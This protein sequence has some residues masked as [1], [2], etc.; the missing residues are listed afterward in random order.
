MISPETPPPHDRDAEAEILRAVIFDNAAIDKVPIED[1]YVRKHQII[2][3]TMKGLKGAGEGFD[4]VVLAAMLE[5]DGNLK[6]AEER[7]YVKE[8]GT[9]FTSARIEQHIEIVREKAHLRRAQA[10]AYKILADVD[11]GDVDSVNAAIEGLKAVDVPTAADE[12]A[13][14]RSLSEVKPTPV[15]WVWPGRI[16][17]GKVTLLVGHPGQGKSLLTLD[18]AARVSTGRGWPDNSEH[19]E[20]GNTILLSGEDDAEDTIV[21]RLLAAGADLDHISIFDGVNCRDPETHAIKIELPALDRH[22]EAICEAVRKADARL[23]VIDPISSFVGHVDDHRNSELR[24]M[25]STLAAMGRDTAC[26]V[27][28][29]SHLRKAGGLAVHQAVGSLAYTAAARAVWCLARVREDPE[30]RL[31]LPVKMNLAKDVGGLAFTLASDSWVSDGAP[32]LV[33][34]PDPVTMTADDVLNP[35]G[36]RPGPPPVEREEACEWLS[37]ALSKGPREASDL[38]AEA[39]ADG[40]S[41]VTL[42]RAKAELA[43]V[44]FKNGFQGPWTWSMPAP[45]KESPKGLTPPTQDNLSPFEET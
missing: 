3:L 29:V 27:L 7:D 42:K 13:V 25:L 18:I 43:I 2:L 33:W 30:R 24:G 35:D 23:L 5:R 19:F 45:A 17:E 10:A 38:F 36:R 44:T 4:A 6:T 11:D 20:P 9:G 34:E 21:P 14:V 1:F 37:I 41:K 26:A 16:P 15:T 8:L 12:T 31:L 32:H 22:M 39:E 40:I 28:C